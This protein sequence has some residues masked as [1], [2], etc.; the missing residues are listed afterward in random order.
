MTSSTRHRGTHEWDGPTKTT[1]ASA[2]LEGM[3]RQEH[4]GMEHR[5]GREHG[6][7]WLAP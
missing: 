5:A 6:S 4:A 1:D 3:Q 7:I 2:F